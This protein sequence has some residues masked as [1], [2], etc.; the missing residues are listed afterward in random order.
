MSRRSGSRASTATRAYF[1]GGDPA[2]T[3]RVDRT[4]DGDAID[5]QR[6]VETVAAEMQATLPEGVQHRPDPHPGRGDHRAARSSARERASWASGWSWC[7]CSCSSTRAPPSGW[8][9]AFPVAMIGG[10]RDDVCG[11]ADAQH[12]LALRADPDA[13]H[14]RRRRHRRGRARRFPRPAAGRRPGDRGRERAA[15]RM[16]VPVFAA[17]L[18][19]V[20]AFFGLVAIGGRFGDADRATSRSR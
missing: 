2:I 14:R 5:M 18:T 15:R 7:S 17:T 12:D 13:R 6:T 1:V 20:I 3:I 10:H 16:F 9:P 19:T 11:G 8:R 4:A